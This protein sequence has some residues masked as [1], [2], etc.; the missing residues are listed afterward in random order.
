MTKEEIKAFILAW[1][2]ASS[3]RQVADKIGRSRHHCSQLAHRLRQKGIG[4][5]MM[6]AYALAK[7]DLADL[8]ATVEE[9]QG[10]DHD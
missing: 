6:R 3:V 7:E 4:L 9:I 10:V 2:T 8:S 5:K 1:E